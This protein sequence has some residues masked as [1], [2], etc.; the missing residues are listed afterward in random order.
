MRTEHAALDVSVVAGRVTR[1]AFV[2]E[3]PL[4]LSAPA[5]GRMLPWEVVDVRPLSAVVT[6]DSTSSRVAVSAATTLTLLTATGYATF[7]VDGGFDA[8]TGNGRLR[9]QLGGCLNDV[10]GVP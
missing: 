9:G 4:Q 6:M 8:Q 3:L 5:L 2:G 7:K 10:F 1:V